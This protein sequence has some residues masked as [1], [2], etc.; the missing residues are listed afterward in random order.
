M[1]SLGIVNVRFAS[2][3]VLFGFIFTTIPL[4]LSLLSLA[5]R[6]QGL[7]INDDFESFESSS[8]NAGNPITGS[9]FSG[10]ELGTVIQSDYAS[11]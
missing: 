2:L 6:T 9:V 4:S 3:C 7:V 1:M 5:T 11:L 8:L 10:S